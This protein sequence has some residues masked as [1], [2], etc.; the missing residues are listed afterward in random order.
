[1]N[2]LD[3]LIDMPL[4]QKQYEFLVS[5]YQVRWW[6]FESDKIPMPSE[7]FESWQGILNLFETILESR[8]Y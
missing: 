2:I 7:E 5:Q 8:Q 3:I 6:D 1:M 4:L